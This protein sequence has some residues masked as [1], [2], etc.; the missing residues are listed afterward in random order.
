MFKNASHYP[1]FIVVVPC[2][3]SSGS[4]LNFFELVFKVYTRGV[5]NRTAIFKDW[6]TSPLYAASFRSCGQAYRFRLK[7]PRIR[8]ALMQILL[9]ICILSQIICV[10]DPKILDTFC[11]FQSKKISNDQE[12]IQSDPISCPPSKPNG[13]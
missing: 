9:N 6:C 4:I 8:L 13:K 3:K 11:V 2:Y 5:S 10:R 1:S 12:L 7:K